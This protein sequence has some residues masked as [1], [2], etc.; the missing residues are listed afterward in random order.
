M[1]RASAMRWTVMLFLAVAAGCSMFEKA[2]PPGAPL[3]ALAPGQFAWNP[4][5]APEGPVEIVVSLASQR[6]FVFRSGTLIGDSTIS[7]GR[8]GHRSPVGR[9]AILQKRKTH[10]SN[11]YSDA[12]MPWMQR[13]NWY[14]VALH[15]GS[16]PG[17]PA[18]HG[19]IRLPM[20]FAEALYGA[21]ELGGFVFVAE[22]Q[23]TSPAAGLKLARAH[24][25]AP[26]GPERRPS[27]ASAAK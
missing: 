4:E 23:V 17:Y 22:G 10:R 6:A 14:G 15:G 21:T 2:P 19:C 11:R 8:A 24:A 26:M 9:F 20:R 16:V 18:S 5:L 7:S 13:L 12:P 27:G 25:A 1:T 3:A